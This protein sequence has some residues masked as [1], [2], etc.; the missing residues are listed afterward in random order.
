VV[1]RLDRLVRA[2]KKLDEDYEQLFSK[3]RFRVAGAAILLAGAATVGVEK[4][5]GGSS[6]LVALPIT[7]GFAVAVM[8][9]FGIW[10]K[11]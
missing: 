2:L 6:G 3:R 5:W 8:T 7:I 1:A 4:V 10:T 9:G 11:L